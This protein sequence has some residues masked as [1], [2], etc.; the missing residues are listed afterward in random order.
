M[1]LRA[2][3]AVETARRERV[4][5]AA[6]GVQM[7]WRAYVARRVFYARHMEWLGRVTKET[8]NAARLIQR[9][10]RGR[11]ARAATRSL[12]LARRLRL[13]HVWRQF[14]RRYNHY[15]LEKPERATLDI[16]R[17]WRGHVGRE[18]YKRE[19]GRT[20]GA[21][22][23][24]VRWY[25]HTQAMDRIHGRPAARV[26]ARQDLILH[27]R[28]YPWPTPELA[29]AARR[30]RKRVSKDPPEPKSCFRCRFP[31]VDPLHDGESWAAVIREGVD[32]AQMGRMPV[33]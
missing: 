11:Q 1:C 16:Q 18:L 29:K 20:L 5:R 19:T 12:R 13:L 28:P 22:K 4:Y 6:I 2:Q 17:V 26:Q 3:R 33:A 25:L 32:Q 14:K 8:K 9:M 24:L 23:R 15:V 7:L 10:E 30:R 21:V 27:A 31:D